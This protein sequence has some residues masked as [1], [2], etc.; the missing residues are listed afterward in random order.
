MKYQKIIE[1]M[2]LEEKVSLLSGKDFWQTKA[3]DR[4]NIPAMFLADGPHGLRKQLAASD[5]LGLNAGAPSTCFPTAA[6][7]ANSW[8]ISLG[9]EI[10]EFLGDEAVAL[11]VNVLL[12]PGLN[13]KR[14]PMCG[15][16]FEY[17]SEDPYLSG[18]MAAAY[19]RGIQSRGIAACPKH[20][21]ANNQELL[22]LASNS[23][24]DERTLREIYLTGFE[25]A[26]KEGHPKTI[27]SSYNQLNGTYTNENE[28][29]LRG[30]LVEEWGFD[31]IVV[32][33]W[34]GSNDRLSG[35][36]AG[37]HLEMPAT[38]GDSDIQLKIAVENGSLSMELLNQRVDEYLQVLFDCQI[39]SHAKKE[40]DKEAHHAMARKA[41]E[42]SI[43]LL[44]NEENIL[45]LKA[46]TKVAVIGDFAKTPRYQGAGSSLV[47]VTK[48][49]NTLDLMEHSGL[50]MIGFEQGFNRNGRIDSAK[51]DAACQLAKSAE[52]VL[53]YLGLDELSE[54][55]GLD[56][57]HMDIAKNQLEVL[58]AIHKVNPNIVVILSCG[59]AIELP[60]MEISKGV[61]HG[62]LSGQA[63][64]GAMLHVLTGKVNPSGKL[65][66]TYPIRHSGTP[67]YEYFPGKERTAEYREGLYVGY[68][69]YDTANTPVCLPF[70]HGLS[71][72]TFTYSDLRITET[73]ASFTISNSGNVAGAEVAQLY[74]HAKN[75]AIFRPY[76]ELKGFIKVFLNPGEKKN[77][78]IPLDEMAFRYFNVNTKQYEVESGI[79]EI[80]IGASSADI[81][82]SGDIKVKGTNVVSPYNPETLPSYYNG[83]IKNVSDK[84]FSELLGYPIPPSLWD[85]S[86]PLERNDT[87]SQLFY[88]K[89]PIARL[90]YRILTRIKEK[91]DAKGTPNL[92]IQFIYYMPFRGIAKMTGGA[93]NIAMVDAILEIVNGHF[94]GGTRHLIGAWVRKG[95]EGKKMKQALKQAGRAEV[96]GND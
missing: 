48:L 12:G 68:R 2:T 5:H 7:I 91:A 38:G 90:V 31:G 76:K 23:V 52:I 34:G 74:V 60:F 10:G 41:A 45:P 25:I 18:K 89:S 95:N 63:G 75:S 13:I 51:L 56:R 47:N 55:E 79:Y 24:M 94:F 70:G 64:A 71:Y 62:Y 54:T 72:T 14:S 96:R 49:D 39:D 16:N 11:Q 43:V 33:D 27:M 9:E 22:R 37:N 50:T 82:L 4:L 8:D 69:Y 65:A 36:V 32:C 17:F 66:E 30:I 26:V 21:A 67:A 92:N 87:I 85:K 57:I 6:T 83:N 86:L 15:R 58:T 35:L 19:I 80:L 59:A 81:R 46:G 42:E 61:V 93:V 29:L 1:K 28:H 20:F 40:F 77:V 53:I 73:E 84:E 3:I 88:A 44:K 78:V